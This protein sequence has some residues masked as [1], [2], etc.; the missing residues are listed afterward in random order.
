M[1][2]TFSDYI[3]LSSDEVADTIAKKMDE[4]KKTMNNEV[5]F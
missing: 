1:K 5:L 4:R 3:K 2:K